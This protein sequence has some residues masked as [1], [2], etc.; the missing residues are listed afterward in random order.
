[1]PLPC[2]TLP[3]KNGMARCQRRER[4]AREQAVGLDLHRRVEVVEEVVVGDVGVRARGRVPRRREREGGRRAGDEREDRL[5]GDREVLGVDL[6]AAVLEGG[7]VD[8]GDAAGDDADAAPHAGA[9][10]RGASASP[11]TLIAGTNGVRRRV[12]V[13][14]GEQDWDRSADSSTK[15][16]ELGL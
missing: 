1:M 16:G 7:G 5:R 8:D 10:G 15:S 12:V 4:V 11:V 9:E 6:A 14:R 13:D 3:R 2:I